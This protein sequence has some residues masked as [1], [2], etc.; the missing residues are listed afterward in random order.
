MSPPGPRQGPVPAPL[1]P[2]SASPLLHS[3][4][5]QSA[6]QVTDSC[7]P[8]PV[9]ALSPWGGS[10]C[11]ACF[12]RLESALQEQGCTRPPR[13][14]L[15]PWH[16]T[17]LVLRVIEA[18]AAAPSSGVQEVAD[19]GFEPGFDLGVGVFQNATPQVAF[20]TQA[21]VSLETLSFLNFY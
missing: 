5:S 12:Q 11:L 2:G 15:N 17:R 19:Q 9:T 6:S 13:L 8:P 3:W 18:G 7:G 14:P 10:S 20:L 16:L 21:R 4:F 1:S